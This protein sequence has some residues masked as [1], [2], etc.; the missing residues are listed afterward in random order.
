[1]GRLLDVCAGVF[2]AAAGIG[3]P[4]AGR[5]G[6][7]NPGPGA[8]SGFAAEVSAAWCAVSPG[9]PAVWASGDGQDVVGV[10]VVGTVRDVDLFR[11]PDRVQRQ[12]AEERDE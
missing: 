6:A 1:M 11:E 7:P 12:G 8:V 10:G 5:E 9:L 3:D 2:A 4:E